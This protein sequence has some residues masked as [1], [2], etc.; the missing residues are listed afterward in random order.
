MVQGNKTNTVC[1]SE[2]LYTDSRFTKTCHDLFAILEAHGVH[3][4]FLKGTNDIWCRDYMPIQKSLDEFV[5]FR[6]EPSYL[7][8]DLDIQSDPKKVCAEN[9]IKPVFSKINLDGG[10]VVNW[11][12]RAMITDRIFDEN[13]NYSSKTQLVSEI[14]K[15]LEVE[16]IIIPQI[17]TDITGHADGLIRFVD[18]NTVIGN[19]R[20]EEYQYWS[21]GIQKVLATHGIEYVDLPFLNHKEIKHK[22]HAI[23]CYINYL[24]VNDLIVLPIFETPY[25][26]DVEAYDTLKQIFPNRTIET[27]N[28]NS[29]GIFGGLLNCTTWTIEESRIADRSLNNQMLKMMF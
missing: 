17:K 26:K 20:R 19:N 16:V 5:Q 4:R 18:R 10:N 11:T 2:K 22:G 29:V 28:Y 7:N 9:N 15:L 1:V 21:K 14:E 25:N 13:P 6:Y 27:L 12:D 8:N 24:E 3:K 23:G